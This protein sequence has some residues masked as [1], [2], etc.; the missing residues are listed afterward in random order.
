VKV[1]DI[2]QTAEAQA[3]QLAG[4]TG[5]SGDERDALLDVLI[6]QTAKDLTATLGQTAARSYQQ[7]DGKWLMNLGVNE[8]YDS[9][10]NQQLRRITVGQ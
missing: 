6:E 10:Q 2:R 1:Y 7:L 5:L 8:N 4:A 3:N 9:G